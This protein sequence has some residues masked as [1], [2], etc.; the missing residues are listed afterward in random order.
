VQFTLTLEEFDEVSQAAR[1]AGVARGTYAAY[2]TLAAARGVPER[3][4][5]PLNE[6]L[7]EMMAATGLVRR[8]GTN[9]NHAVAK[10]NATGQRSE[11][12]LPAAQFCAR[13]IGGLRTRRSKCA[14]AFRE[15]PGAH[16]MIGKVIWGTDARRL[17]YYLYGP[18]KANEH[19]DPRVVAGFADPAGLEPERR[20]NGSR[21][22]RRLAALLA[23]PL[24]AVKGDNYAKAVWHCADRAA[25][26]DRELSDGEW[27]RVAA[28]IMDQ[29]GLWHP[30]GPIWP[31]GRSRSGTPRITSTWSPRWPGRTGSGRRYGTTTSGCGRVPGRGTVVRAAGH[32]THSPRSC[33]R[34]SCMPSCGWGRPHKPMPP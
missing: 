33:A 29:T 24:A 26:E 27:A 4:V 1:R 18:G 13:V 28:H 19:A 8:I 16:R 23:Q 12:L 7:G 2:V 31:C 3:T 25:P 34:S 32:R 17:L 30:R 10:L 20:Q 21:D 9:L 5:S 6:A 22:L 15:C 14:G 11:D